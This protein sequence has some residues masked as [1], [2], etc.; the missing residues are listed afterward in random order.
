MKTIMML[1]PSLVAIDP[2][3]FVH[4]EL[5]F[6]S[7]NSIGDGDTIILPMAMKLHEK[8]KFYEVLC[9]EMTAIF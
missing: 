2:S 5:N 4:F 9:E 7:A 6:L 1:V 3:V 8:I